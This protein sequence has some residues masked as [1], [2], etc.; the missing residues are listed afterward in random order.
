M[1]SDKLLV[2]LED[3]VEK[4]KSETLDQNSKTELINFYMR[5]NRP[6]NVEDLDEEDALKFLCMG[7][8][9]YNEMARTENKTENRTED[10]T[11]NKITEAM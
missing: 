8:Y 1:T 5:V 11:T 10:K 2:F 7:W 9:I 6:G 4:L 3:I